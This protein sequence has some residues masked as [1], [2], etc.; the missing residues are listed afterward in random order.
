MKCCDFTE[1]KV[2]PRKF[3][4]SWPELQDSA[5]VALTLTKRGEVSR[6]MEFTELY[7]CSI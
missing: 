5:N 2:L 1:H 3:C 6:K 7:P 4:S